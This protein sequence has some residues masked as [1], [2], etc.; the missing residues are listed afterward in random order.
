MN[1]TRKLIEA[2]QRYAKLKRWIIHRMDNTGVTPWMTEMEWIEYSLLSTKE[3]H[4]IRR[5][6]LDDSE[7][8]CEYDRNKTGLWKVLPDD[9]GAIVISLQLGLDIVEQLFRGLGGC[10][11]ENPMF[12]ATGHKS[13]DDCN[14]EQRSLALT[15][16]HGEREFSAGSD[17]CFDAVNGGEMITAPLQGENVWEVD[18]A[19]IPK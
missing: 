6:M 15:A 16:G 13:P 18:F 7:I 3:Y 10:G 14:G 12:D 9:V 11:N 4:R 1:K 19:K 17:C 2:D 8:Q 5:D